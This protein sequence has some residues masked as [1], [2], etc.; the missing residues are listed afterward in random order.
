MQFIIKSFVAVLLI[1]PEITMAQTTYL[2]L[3]SKE[4]RLIDEVLEQK[5]L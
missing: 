1:V 2:P 4:Y 5:K 3:E